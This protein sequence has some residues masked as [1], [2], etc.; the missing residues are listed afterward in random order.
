MGDFKN[1]DPGQIVVTFDGNPISGF[2]DG[3]MVK[4]SRKSDT[5]TTNVGTQGDVAR[6]RSQDKTGEVVITLQQVSETNDYLSGVLALDEKIGQSTGPIL[7]KDLNGTT[8][9]SA[10]IAW[11][12]KP[13]D[14]EFGKDLGP[15]EWTFE[16]AEL[17]MLVGGSLV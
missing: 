1:Y 12:K 15:R 8:L 6:V 13:A 7:V 16:C 11:L 4:C 9:I 5:F 2:A 17:K 10:T 14:T 3:T